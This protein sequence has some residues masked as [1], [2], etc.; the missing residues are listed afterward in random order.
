M[1]LRAEINGIKALRARLKAVG[2]NRGVLRLLAQQGVAEAK[3]LVPHQT[4]HLAR[5]IR[6][7]TVTETSALVLAGGPLN[8]GYARYVEEGTGLYGPHR[9]KIVPRRA[10]VLRWKGGG[11]RVTGRGKGS[12]WIV[13]RSVKGRRAT[14]YLVPG[15]RKG[16]AKGGFKKNIVK[17]WDSAA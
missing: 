4:G 1:A 2:D 11:S 16:L 14:P 6:V 17:A 3:R 13:A 10:K 9:R 15:V 12:R 5:T 7:G 8:V